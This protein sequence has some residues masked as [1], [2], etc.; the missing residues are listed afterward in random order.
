MGVTHDGENF[1]FFDL[2]FQWIGETNTSGNLGRT[3]FPGDKTIR[4]L[5]WDGES[6]WAVNTSG[7]ISQYTTSGVALQTISGLLT[8]GWG[9]TFDGTHLWVSDPDSDKLYKIALHDRIAGDV[10]GDGATDQDDVVAVLRHILHMQTL[11]GDA[12]SKADCNGDG[13]ITVIDALGIVNLILE[14]GGCDS[15]VSTSENIPEIIAYVRSLET[16]FSPDEL[17]RCVSLLRTGIGIPEGY[18][19]L[20]NYPNPFNPETEIGFHL[21]RDSKVSLIVYNALGQMV[22][23][24]ID[25]ILP[26][27]HHV[28]FWNAEHVPSGVYFYSL[29]AETFTATRRMVLMK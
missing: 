21:P 28:I 19:L 26:A 4:D 11:Q 8:G 5:S 3:F 23:V 24:L 22:N 14:F 18:G 10:T 27:G 15:F 9:L 12:F 2:G 13:Q 29:Q 1:W 6:I 20:Q 17:S 16:S 7:V 25:G